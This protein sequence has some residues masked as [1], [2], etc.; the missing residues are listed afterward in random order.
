M[1]WPHL[2]CAYLC[3][4][5]LL[6]VLRARS[7]LSLHR[8]S[9]EFILVVFAFGKACPLRNLAFIRRFVPVSLNEC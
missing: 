5:L 7:P 6:L 9:D 1:I 4:R 2:G 8:T 3:T